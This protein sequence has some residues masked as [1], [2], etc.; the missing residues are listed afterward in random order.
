M[1]LGH[2]ESVGHA[3]DIVADRLLGPEL[4]QLIVRV[5]MYLIIAFSV[6][7]FYL[8]YEFLRQIF[9]MA[10]IVVEHL[11]YQLLRLLLLPFRDGIRVNVFEH[12]L[13]KSGHRGAD[14]LGHDNV[15]LIVA[16]RN[17]VVNDRI[18][19]LA[20]RMSEHFGIFLGNVFFVDYMASD[21]VIDIM[22]DVRDLI[23]EPYDL[24]LKRRRRAL[25]LVVQD[26]VAHLAGQVH[27]PAVLLNL[28]ELYDADAL[29]MMCKADGRDIVQGALAR[30]SERS[31]PEI[32]SERDGLGQVLVKAQCLRDGP[33]DLRDLKRVRHTVPVMITHGSKEYL[34]LAVQSSER[35]RM[36]DPV[37]VALVLGPDV[38]GSLILVPARR[39]VAE[40]RVPAQILMFS[41]FLLFSDR[42]HFQ[43]SELFLA[44]SSFGF[45]K[46]QPQK[47]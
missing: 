10:D 5:K 39:T 30:V 20:G 8:I 25:C 1:E 37:A 33:C 18:Q 13:A 9:G 28:K 42:I 44:V 38:A 27:M 40:G 11:L 6:A 45:E 26:T 31:V 23:G 2:R 15:G 14:G 21:G 12:I 7:V 36:N 43:T 16:R 29:L 17:Y 32:V 46:S 34:R 47:F 4:P 24:A 3:R 19:P 35:L 22:V 41:R